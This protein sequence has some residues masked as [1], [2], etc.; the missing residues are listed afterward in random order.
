LKH[1]V[2]LQYG[3]FNT[4][5]FSYD[6]GAGNESAAV[7]ASLFNNAS[8]NDYPW[9]GGG[10][11]INGQFY[12]RGFDAAAG[13]RFE[14]HS[15]RFYSRM[16]QAERH[17]SLIVPSE[18]KTKIRNQNS[19]NLL[20]WK[21]DY[22]KFTTTAKVAFLNESY[23]FY[24]RLDA[25][26]QDG[27][28]QTFL[29]R[30]DVAWQILPKLTLH[31]V[32]EYSTVKG[33]GRNITEET[34]ETASASV[35][36]KYQ[37]NRNWVFEAGLRK[38]FVADY[39]S[40]MLFSGAAIYKV[41]FYKISLSGS[42]NFRIPSFNDRYWFQ[43]GNPNLNPET[44]WQAELGQ[45]I[46]F[47]NAGLSVAVYVIK[48]E[49]MIQWLPGTSSMW[50]PENVKEVQSQGIEA[51]GYYRIEFGQHKINLNGIYTY[52]H[53]ENRELGKQLIYVPFHRATLGFGYNFRRIEITGESL[54]T[55]EVFTRSDNNPRYNLDGFAVANFGIG[56]TFDQK[57]KSRIGISIRNAFDERYETMPRRPYPGRHYAANLTFNF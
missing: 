55:G 12:N 8:D 49:D 3:S 40:P 15:I 36:S 7:R 16:F 21:S 17:F 32:V 20:E 57:S 6:V 41:G 11:N 10:K 52:T 29:A 39:Q 53:S 50:Y 27:N 30:Y 56:W 19:S 45:S 22:S 1:R 26:K 35:L 23:A 54:M 48:I 25:D 43:G 4:H 28:A 13:Y 24:E 33:W 37:A 34:R 38:E 31:P 44:S 47:E 5:N 51:S 42:R 2:G 9:P 18:T 46:E 14:R